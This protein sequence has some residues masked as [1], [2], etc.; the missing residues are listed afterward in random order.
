MKMALI[1]ALSRFKRAPK[2]VRVLTNLLLAYGCY[3]MLLALLIPAVIQSQAPKKLSELLGRD[4]R[5]AEASINP[6][7]LRARISGFEISEQEKPVNF[8]SFQQLEL[9]FSFWRSLLQFTPSLD[10]LHIERPQINITRLAAAADNPEFNF[11]DI[12]KRLTVQQSE[13]PRP[14]ANQAPSGIPPFRARVIK[15]EQGSFSFQ[16]QQTDANLQYQGLNF[17]LQQ[18]DSQALTLN[19][20]Q[21]TSADKKKP[22]FNPEANRYTFAV[23]GADQGQLQLEGQ[24]QLQP[25]E[26]RGELTLAKVT[27][28]PF[29]PFAAKLVK[30]KL[31]S[32][33]V[34]VESSFHL[35]QEQEQFS[36]D[37]DKGRFVLANLAFNDNEAP[38]VKLPQLV[39]DG[40]AL[41]SA[42]QTVDLKALQ[43]QGIWVDASL[44]DKG[45]DLQQLFM[46]AGTKAAEDSA[47][48]N[49]D[50]AD[51][52]AAKGWQVRLNSFEMAD[53]D[54]NLTENLISQG[55]H[56][57]IYPL[58]LSTSAVLSDLSQPLDYQLALSLSS[59]TKAPPLNDR[60]Q[61]SSSGSL[62]AKTLGI[63]GKLQL[64]ALDLSQFQPYLES[65]LNLQL[66]SGSLTTGGDFSANHQG[67]VVYQGQA[68]IDDLLIKDRLEY[69]PLLKWQQMSID[70][71]QFDLQNKQMKIDNIMLDAPYAKVL[72]AKDRRTN[73]SEILVTET[74]TPADATL[75]NK[76]ES[77]T[78]QSKDTETTQSAPMT[79]EPQPEQAFAL[80]IG[81]IKIAK[82]SAYFADNS[83]TPNF[84]SGIESLE[85]HISHLSST[86]STKA[87]VDL[88]GKID[89]YAPMTLSGEI[90]PLLQSPYLDLDLV[91]NSVE[92][93]SVNPYSGTYVGYYID[94]GQ[95][96]LTL[97]YQLENNQL[98]G[99]NHLVIDQL[100]LGKPSESDLATSLPLTLGIALLQDRH[101]VIDLGLDVSGDVDSPDFSFGSIIMNAITNVITKAV[102]AP[103]SLLA[104]LAGTDEELS[105]VQFRPGLASLDTAEQ[106][107]LSKL[108][109]ALDDRPILKVSIEGSVALADDSKALAEEKLQQELLQ[110]SGLASLPQ[111]LSASRFPASGPLATALERLF[112]QQLK[113][114]INAERAKVEQ[115]LKEKAN[116]EAELDPAQITTVVHIG[117]YNQLL[118]AQEISHSELGNLAEARARAIKAFMVNDKMVN[119]ERVFLLDSKS[120]LN[121]Q[122]SRAMLTLSA[123]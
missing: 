14:D 64:T 103:F 99:S 35:K 107:R 75:A 76:P 72:I 33:E 68:A 57:R 11:S 87:Q 79:T 84:A 80:D 31:S 115:M 22:Q 3:A 23:T 53:T 117:M 2:S 9:E 16:D 5:I 73:I 36:F 63:D 46:P 97:N 21:I 34:N 49:P 48:G 60:G 51:K 94:K 30:A 109:K 56:W 41:S 54:L 62:D 81:S 116:T 47:P 112:V 18:L 95:L 55:V 19:Q 67:K 110:L 20:P 78:V 17:S 89:K 32:G 43:V 29:W 118:N 65:F 101:G 58:T 70:A 59:D 92:L 86:P 77:E 66:S 93:T 88:K 38:K 108:A 7:L 42:S 61:F 37:T 104:D 113:L 119:P 74:K 12:L 102:T 24:F 85:G 40:I 121:T 71:L 1:H 25:L 98:K 106:D 82:G 83:L 8:A 122:E 45:L 90:N 100:Q 6:F 13:A 10:H 114:D 15:I 26:I 96:S 123:S 50:A 44:N 28:P 91:F 39:V 4:V 52:A 105:H 27:L 69:Q 120:Q 111:D